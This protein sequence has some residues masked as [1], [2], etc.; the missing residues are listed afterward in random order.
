[1]SRESQGKV[2]LVQTANRKQFTSRPGIGQFTNALLVA[3]C[4]Y[5]EFIS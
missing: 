4:D 3:G 1:M 5:H 2:T